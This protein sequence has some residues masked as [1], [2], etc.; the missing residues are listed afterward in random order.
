MRVLTK[1][2]KGSHREGEFEVKWKK[3]KMNKANG[4]FCLNTQKDI[5]IN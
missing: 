1:S 4:L 2:I 3:K 5:S